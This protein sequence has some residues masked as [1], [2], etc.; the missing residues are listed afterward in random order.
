MNKNL[1]FN[2][3]IK[4]EKFKPIALG[5]NDEIIIRQLTISESIA[6]AIIPLEVP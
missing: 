3:F 4:E 5:G 1:F 6:I 2:C